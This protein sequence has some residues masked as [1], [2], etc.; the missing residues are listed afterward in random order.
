MYRKILVPLDGSSLAEGVLPH[1]RMLAEN[2]DAEIVL[3]QIVVDPIYDL[4]LSGP[5]L[6]AATHDSGSTQHPR[7]QSYLDCVAKPLR[8]AG[9]EVTTMVCEG[10][11]AETILACGERFQVDLIVMAT[12]GVN[13]PSGWQLGNVTYRIVHDA[14]A[15]VL[16]I[17]AQQPSFPGAELAMAT[18]S[19]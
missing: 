17:R 9:L 6:A 12:H 14:K 3:L 8:E 13:T 18:Q 5:K 1:V 19:N 4:L 11:V 10:L 15:P 2:F 16:L 7:S